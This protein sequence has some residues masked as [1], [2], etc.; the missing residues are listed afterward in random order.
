VNNLLDLLRRKPSIEDEVDEELNFHIDMQTHD[1]ENHG[2]SHEESRARAAVRFGNVAQIKKEC[3][4]IGSGKTI[5]IWILDA[6]F[7]MSLIMGLLLRFFVPEYH[8]NRVGTIMMMIGGL[9]I[10]LVY[11]KQAGAHVFNSER[12][13]PLGL[14]RNSPPI[15]FD[16]QGR[17]PFDRVRA[18]D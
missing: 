8:V 9:G 3:I 4:R 18:D 14:N 13:N 16:E 1:Y 5:L 12:R 7:M 17:T 11:A 6:V 2:L 15:G 10:L